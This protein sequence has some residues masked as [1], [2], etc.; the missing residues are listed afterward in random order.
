MRSV[1]I[2]NNQ[3]SKQWSLRTFFSC[4]SVHCA[5]THRRCLL[6]WLTH[7]ETV[8]LTWLL[9][10]TVEKRTRGTGRPR[11]N[12]VNTHPL[13]GRVDKVQIQSRIYRY[14]HTT[15]RALNPHFSSITKRT[16]SC[17]NATAKGGIIVRNK[18]Y[19]LSKLPQCTKTITNVLQ[20]CLLV[21]SCTLS[22]CKHKTS[23]Q[24]KTGIARQNNVGSSS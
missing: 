23:A 15:H 6:Q 19:I 4:V 24:S 1:A 20:K 12:Q 13:H 21:H 2:S 8:S 18:T 14:W 11:S 22:K 16:Q 5:Q 7:H 10:T 3:C 17:T 9:T